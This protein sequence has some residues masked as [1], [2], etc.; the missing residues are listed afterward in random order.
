MKKLFECAFEIFG[1][2]D[3][4]NGKVLFR[5]DFG[6]T[7]LFESDALR[8]DLFVER[9]GIKLD[10][11]FTLFDLF[12]VCDDPN[13]R[14]SAPDLAFDVDVACAFDIAVFRDRD[15]QVGGLGLVG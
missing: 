2:G 15:Q 3:L 13:N 10:Q 4:G 6:G 9:G 7:S 1:D 5:L 11:F 8:V 12:S 14:R